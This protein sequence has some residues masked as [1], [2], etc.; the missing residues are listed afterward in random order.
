M[1]SQPPTKTQIR[2]WDPTP[3]GEQAAEW[4]RAAQAV[5]DQHA[6]VS[7]QLADS[8]EIW[9]GHAA[10]AMRGKGDEARGSLS[11][12]SGALERGKTATT[13]IAQSLSAAKTAAVDAIAAAEHERFIVGED[14]TVAFDRKMLL[15]VIKENQT[16]WTLAYSMLQKIAQRHE[17]VIK[18][19]LRSAGDAAEAARN[20]LEQAFAEVPLPPNAELEGIL[21]EYQVQ[22]DPEGMVFWPDEGLLG[23]LGESTDNAKK[24]TAGEAE[25]LDQLS[26]G[27]KVR[28]YD[29]M[30]EAEDTALGMYPGDVQQDD[31]TDAFRHVYWNAMMTQEFGEDWTNEYTSKHEGRDDN[32]AV[33]EAMDLHNN[34]IGR[35]IA[36]QNP[37][38]SREELKDLTEQAVARGDAVLINQDQSL[39]W[40][41]TVDVGQTVDSGILDEYGHHLPGSLMPDDNPSPK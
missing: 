4:G 2:A 36:L 40:T 12:V 9:R 1:S 24:V 32:K 26:L 25:M 34:E 22:S 16:T 7:R 27:D 11:K 38:A 15:W 18:P 41:N 5:N 23:F 19:A 33:R 3:L 35:T 14:G 13:G 8:P 31:H 29:M 37:D 28:F 39:S 21:N 20:A 10:D 17:D 6:A 30:T